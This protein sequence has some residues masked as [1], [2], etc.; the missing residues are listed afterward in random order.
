MRT[1]TA[2]IITAC[3]VTHLVNQASSADVPGPAAK[4]SV[5]WVNVTG[6]VGGGKWGYA[7]VTKVF[8]VPGT[9][10]VIAGV[11]ESGLW[12]SDD[13]GKT[14]AKLGAEDKEQI[15]HRPHQMVFDP[16]DVKT[17]WVS[18]CYGAG[19]FKTTDGGKSFTRLGDPQHVDGVGID[20]SDPDRK[21]LLIGLH[22]QA[23]SI[24]KSTDGG[25]TWQKIGDRLPA[26]SNH[27][28]DPIVLDS[29]T[30]LCNTAGWA[31][32]ATWG[33]YRSEDAGNTWEKVS[34]Q[35]PQSPALVAAD[36]SIYWMLCYG[37]GLVKSSDRGK[38]WKKLTGPVKSSPIE[39]GD[40]KIAGL[41][42]NQIWVS[43]DGGEKWEKLGDVIPFKPNGIVYSPA[44]KALYAWR[45]TDK[46]SDESIVRWEMGN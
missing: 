42:G 41:G 35:G 46:K 2:M 37:N 45:M 16:K 5:Q 6:N 34:D 39:L 1:R 7:G 20:F 3:V 10:R 22:E 9:M 29:K 27:S 43:S 19:V 31:Q 15:K 17:F 21:T 11:S 40:G 12:A 23:R 30:F 28:S 4:P 44:G 8:A 36:G 25:K 33:I 13:A 14:W 24:H 18:G 26:D 32:K 38:T